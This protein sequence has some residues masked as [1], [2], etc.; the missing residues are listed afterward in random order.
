ME[1]VRSLGMG[2]FLEWG[3]VN[4]KGTIGEVLVF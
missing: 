2:R 4:V 1:I 3:F